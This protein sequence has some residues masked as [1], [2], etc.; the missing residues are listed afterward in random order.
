MRKRNDGIGSLDLF[1]IRLTPS[2]LGNLKFMKMLLSKNKDLVKI[3]KVKDEER[4]METTYITIKR[5]E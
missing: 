3:K 4:G 5:T 2:P 1:L